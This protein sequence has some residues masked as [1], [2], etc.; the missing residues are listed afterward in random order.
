MELENIHIFEQKKVRTM[1][2]EEKQ[3][4]FFSIVDVCAILT[5]QDDYDL[6]KNYW[7]VLK[8]R[9]IK[10]GNESV[11]KCNQLKLADY[12]TLNVPPRAF[13]NVPLQIWSL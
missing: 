2:D 5:D 13:S 1:W 8:H 10:E 6:A 7:K 12:I 4:W 11:T 3:E 9:L